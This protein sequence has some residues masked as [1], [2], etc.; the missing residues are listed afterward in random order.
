MKILLI[1]DAYPP[2]KTS[3]AVLFDDLCQ[4][5]RRKNYDLTVVLPDSHLKKSWSYGVENGIKVL[6]LSTPVTKDINFFRRT[7]NESLLSFFMYLNLRKSPLW[8]QRWDYIIWHSPTI[9]F[10]PLIKLL[11][12]K[13]K[14]KTYLILRDI[15]PEWAL[16]LGILKK[17]IIYN[18]FKF[19]EKL[20]YSVADIIG[21]QTP[22]NLLY[23][24]QLDIAHN[25]KIVV[26]N[27]WIT[28]NLKPDSDFTVDLSKFKNRIIFVYAGNMGVAQNLSLLIET[29]KI[30]RHN[31]EIGFLFVGRGGEKEELKNNATRNGLKNIIFLDEINP[32]D[33]PQLY[34]RCHSGLVMLD[35]RHKTHNIPGKFMGY[36]INGLPVVARINPGND[37]IKIIEINKLGRYITNDSADDFS[38]KILELHQLLKHDKQLIDRCVTFAQNNFSTSTAVTQIMHDL[39]NSN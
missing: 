29:A 37:L 39:T 2:M 30:L 7:I 1:T 26:L 13:T 36:L 12:I 14:A 31:E 6:R 3:T 4:E 24:H 27:N 23:F 10:G 22:A 38:K 9:F 28:D 32:S 33:I 35:I 19:F 17:G 5:F 11:K 21:V 15:F 25:P 20:Q 18:F 8:T 16:N 34:K